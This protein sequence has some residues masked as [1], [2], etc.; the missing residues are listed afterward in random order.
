VKGK[1]WGIIALGVSLFLLAG[2]MDRSILASLPQ[3][4]LALQS[5]A[6]SIDQELLVACASSPNS[7][8]GNLV[9]GQDTPGGAL[10]QNEIEI[11]EPIPGDAWSDRAGFSIALPAEAAHW[12]AMLGSGW[13]LDWDVQEGSSAG[14][15]EHWQIV[16]LHESCISPSP[17]AIQSTASS[18]PGRV[19]I[20]GNEPDVI[21][22][23]DV[24]PRRYAVFY[25]A[26]YGL[27]KAADPGAQIA[28]G[29]V[30]QATP[31]RLE[32]LDQVLGAYQELYGQSLP[33]DWWTV[34]GYV[35]R[36]Q[37][38]SWG[39]EIPPGIDAT[40]GMLYEVSDHGRLDLFESQ[41]I[42][43]RQWM[44]AH[45]YQDTPLAL[46]EFGILMPTSYGFPPVMIADYLEQ[47]FTWLYQAQDITSGFPAD[48]YRLVQKW[49][50]YSI[51]DSTYPSSNLGDISNGRLTTLGERFRAV[52]SQK[53]Q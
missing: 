37:Q 42:A 18:Y 46:T 29:G 28:V 53:G 31:L 27:I 52:V 30:S 50:W 3:T 39:V 1:T 48:D 10:S 24:T 43:F 20:I 47:T 26:L 17:Q 4:D 14:G 6:S 41:L 12:A 7:A 44:K 33:A 23:D 13:Y 45:G 19:W 32:Y 9:P 8:A 25:H 51:A 2:L 38:D 22:Q 35:L 49:A 34:H 11:S 15:P 21:W 16:R 40:Q 5:I 36:E